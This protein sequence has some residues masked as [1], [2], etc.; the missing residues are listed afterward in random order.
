VLVALSSSSDDGGGGND[1]DGHGRRPTTEPE[2][3]LLGL[4]TVKFGAACRMPTNGMSSSRHFHHHCIATFFF[5]LF[6][7]IDSVT[8]VTKSSGNVTACCSYH[9][10]QGIK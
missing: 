1:N 3:S 10:R 2:R 7:Q 4:A 9:H 6:S 8:I 5:P